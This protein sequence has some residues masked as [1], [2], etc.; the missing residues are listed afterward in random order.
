MKL[1]IIGFGEFGL[2]IFELAERINN[3]QHLWKEIVFVETEAVRDKRVI[4]ENKFWL[5]CTPEEYECVIAVGEVY[6]REKIY[7]KYKQRGYRFATLIDSRASVSRSAKVK[8]GCLIF[9]FVY[10]AHDCYVAENT[11]LHAHSIIEN[12]CIIGQHCFISLG[13]FV[14]A[15]TE[16]GEVVFVGPNTTVRD[17]IKIGHYTIIGMGS[18]VIHNI[19]SKEVWVGNPAKFIRENK[20]FKIG[21]VGKGNPRF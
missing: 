18:V 20:D 5:Y 1:A 16:I 19:G 11:I 17:K 7:K 4:E 12:D 14:G 9:P 8:E 3:C 15:C 2:E 21:L 10:V 6:L 13:A